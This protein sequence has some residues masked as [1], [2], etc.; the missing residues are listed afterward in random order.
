MLWKVLP[1]MRLWDKIRAD[2]SDSASSGKN[3]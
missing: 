1:E 3:R 2:E